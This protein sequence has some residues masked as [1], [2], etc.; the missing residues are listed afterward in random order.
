MFQLSFH[1]QD[2]TCKK[3]VKHVVTQAKNKLVI[4]HQHS[5]K[6]QCTTPLD[7]NVI[8]RYVVVP[9]PMDLVEE[10]LELTRDVTWSKAPCEHIHILCS[11][12]GCP[13]SFKT[14]IL[15]RGAL[16]HDT[17]ALTQVWHAGTCEDIG[18]TFQSSTEKGTRPLFTVAWN[19]T[20]YSGVFMLCCEFFSLHYTAS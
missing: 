12:K 14:T 1:F 3:N 16:T 9:L 18:E 11:S 5:T 10:F 20:W 13:I 8:F 15:L 19:H 6:L 17:C 2:I 7:R 4:H